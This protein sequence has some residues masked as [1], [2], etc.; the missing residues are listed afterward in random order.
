MK[1]TI[2][3]AVEKVLFR[4]ALR[5]GGVVPLCRA[6]L[7]LPFALDEVEAAADT[8]ADGMAVVKN[9]WGEFLTYEFPEL[10]RQQPV[11][12]ATCP[13][14]GGAPPP[15]PT[16]GGAEVRP[17]LVCDACYRGLRLSG[18]STTSGNDS[19]ALT[20]VKKLF[21]GGDG[22]PEDPSKVARCEHEIF[23]IG[24]SLGVEQ[25]THATIAAQSR[26]PANEIK[27]RLDA[28]AARRYI[29]VGLLPSGDAV[30]FRFP[31]GL[32]YPRP[33]YG[34]I[35]DAGLGGTADRSGRLRGLQVTPVESE[36]PP[37]PKPGLKIVVTPKGKRP[38]PR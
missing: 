13:T 31:P 15:V 30:G 24:L 9:E 37:P 14:C 35:N 38:P 25:F 20:R 21:S 22:E 23:F 27:A 7:E 18:R 29:H 12:P 16:Q 1:L 3:H 17:A 19:S 26:F 6:F 4:I 5:E 33:H 11:V 36:A 8:V 28:M 34:R 10:M 2:A 32:T